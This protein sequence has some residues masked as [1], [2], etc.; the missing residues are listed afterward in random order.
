MT[1]GAS[2][3]LDRAACLGCSVWSEPDDVTWGIVVADPDLS[4]SIGGDGA[5]SGTGLGPDD[6]GIVPADAG[7]GIAAN[8]VSPCFLGPEIDNFGRR[9]VPA[10]YCVDVLAIAIIRAVEQGTRSNQMV[11]PI[12]RHLGELI[13]PD[14]R[15]DTHLG[16]DRVVCVQHFLGYRRWRSIL[17]RRGIRGIWRIGWGVWRIIV[18]EL[19][20]GTI[21]QKDNDQ[22]EERTHGDWPYQQNV[23]GPWQRNQTP[24]NIRRLAKI[25]LRRVASA[26]R[27]AQFGRLQSVF[28][29][30]G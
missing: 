13:R 16:A 23:A 9:R 17:G 21:G 25:A 11:G 26:R 2:G 15:W 7:A 19:R 6:L 27:P 29:V 24:A 5:A 30:G 4:P 28:S 12:L 20:L 22:G 8:V 1:A 18:R 10:G 3:M 14:E